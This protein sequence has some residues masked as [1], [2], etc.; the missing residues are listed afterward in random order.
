MIE[1]R[2]QT[3][4]SRMDQRGRKL[5]PLDR[6]GRSAADIVDVDPA[7][8]SLGGTEAGRLPSLQHGT[9]SGQLSP[10][11]RN[12]PI[13]GY[14]S[15][16]ARSVS[17]G[18]RRVITHAEVPVP[19][20]AGPPNFRAGLLE[21]EFKSEII[22]GMD[23]IEYYSTFGHSSNIKLFH[24]VSDEPSGHPYNL[25]V[26]AYAAT[27]T[28][29]PQHPTPQ[30]GLPHYASITSMFFPSFGLCLQHQSSQL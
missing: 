11:K 21:A 23:V 2:L 25:R 15:G 6:G 8:L 18:K 9:T 19:A 30:S 12:T 20:K 16:H 4:P 26:L 24:L 27:C 10:N 7:G 17:T 29:N 1:N 13:L 28:L 5:P 14:D 3:Q 22:T